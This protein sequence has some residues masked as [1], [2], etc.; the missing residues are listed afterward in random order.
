[1]LT[2]SLGEEE[3]SMLIKTALG[4]MALG[5]FGEGSCNALNLIDYHIYF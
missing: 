1:M 3:R 2:L 4:E 5:E